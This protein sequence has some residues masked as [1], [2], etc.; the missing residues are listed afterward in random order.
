[1]KKV[2]YYIWAILPVFIKQFLI[3]TYF[4]PNREIKY[5]SVNIT[6]ILSKKVQI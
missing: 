6:D 3:N 5:G 4:L 2:K 1:M